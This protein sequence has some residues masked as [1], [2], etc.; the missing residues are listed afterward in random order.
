M[1][2]YNVA[3]IDRYTHSL[4]LYRK[5]YKH[6]TCRSQKGV[7]SLDRYKMLYRLSCYTMY[8]SSIV[9]TMLQ[10][11]QRSLDFARI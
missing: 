1:S 3:L 5:L 11:M 9:V 4:A 10:P 2:A 8:G 6:S 7:R